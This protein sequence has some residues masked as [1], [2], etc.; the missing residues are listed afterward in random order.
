MLE[1][2]VV[3][4]KITQTEKYIIEY[5]HKINGEK[6]KLS[7]FLKAFEENGFEYN[8]ITEF[9]KSVTSQDIIFT[10]YRNSD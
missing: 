5:H 1:D 3:K 7:S 6:S 2:L 4:R 10:F 9:D 8:L